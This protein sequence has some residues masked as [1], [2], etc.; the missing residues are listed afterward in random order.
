MFS[1]IYFQLF[2]ETKHIFNFDIINAN[3]NLVIDYKKH[4][5]PLFS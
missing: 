4:I 2:I 5:H 1:V 3:M